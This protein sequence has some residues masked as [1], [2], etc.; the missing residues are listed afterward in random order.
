M[1]K[2]YGS[3]FTSLKISMLFLNFGTVLELKKVVFLQLQGQFHLLV[4]SVA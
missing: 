1:P 3:N 4:Q 2:K